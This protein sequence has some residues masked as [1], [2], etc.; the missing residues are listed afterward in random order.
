L[1]GVLE[2]VTQPA[3]GV[4]QQ[5]TH[6][7]AL[8]PAGHMGAEMRQIPANLGLQVELALI[9]QAQGS[10]AGECLGGGGDPEHVVGIDRHRVIDVCD[11]EAADVVPATVDDAHGHPR[12]VVPRH[13]RL[14]LLIQLGEQAD[15]GA[16]AKRPRT[17][18][19]GHS[20]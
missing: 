9:D 4:V 18:G 11:A 17:S 5:L 16:I 15:R 14:H 8:G 12:D 7:H 1:T 3:G 10:G 6:G 13:R 20:R 2:V 19:P